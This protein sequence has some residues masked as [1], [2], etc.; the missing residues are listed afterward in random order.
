MK[1]KIC[2]MRDAGNI[3]AVGRFRPDYMGFIFYEKSPRF[4]GD[5]DPEVLDALPEGVR[6][7]GVFVDAPEE[8]VRLTAGRY[9]LD[10]IQ[11]HGDETPEYC[12]T[13]RRQIPV[14]K[15]FGVADAGDLER[16]AAYENA[17]DY[18]LF[19]TKTPG[20]G[21]AGTKFDHCLLAGYRGSTPYFLSG[22]IGPGDAHLLPSVGDPR[23]VAVDVNSRFETAPA[24]K[25]AES[26]GRFI[27]EIRDL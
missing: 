27:R 18:F 25:D 5:L 11:L 22:G 17:C 6:R 16:A 19:D 20:R 3:A 8:F 24:I 1:I 12:R 23:C 21:G 26:V 13:L 9:R 7:V 15:A 2:G 4:A 10:L 14:V